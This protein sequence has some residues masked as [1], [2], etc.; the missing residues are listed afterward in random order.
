LKFF[1]KSTKEKRKIV[2]GFKGCFL[3]LQ[4]G[5]RKDDCDA[6]RKARDCRYC[7]GK[8]HT[9]LHVEDE[10]TPNGE[11]AG[12]NHSKLVVSYNCQT[13]DASRAIPVETAILTQ[14][15]MIAIDD[16]NEFLPV[17][18]LFDSGANSNA[19]SSKLA[20]KL[21]LNL[22]KKAPYSVA[23]AGG[24]THN[25]QAASAEIVL[26]N[27]DLSN[28]RKMSVK[29]YGSPVGS[30]EPTNWS[31]CKDQW[32]HLRHLQVAPP[33]EGGV[34]VLIGMQDAD[35]FETSTPS[36][37]GKPGEPVAKFTCLGWTIAGR[38]RRNPVPADVVNLSSAIAMS[39]AEEYKEELISQGSQQFIVEPQAMNTPATMSLTKKDFDRKNENSSCER[40]GKQK[41]RRNGGFQGLPPEVWS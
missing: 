11:S 24:K 37:V 25:Y 21:G 3:C 19:M 17:N 28:K 26:A 29:V 41:S 7:S 5:H 34:D 9:W 6:P 32:E 33:V 18:V 36:I 23:V 27:M 35:A 1:G 22:T 31:E 4:A 16:E 15:G 2:E 39:V 13:V 20:K 40:E 12:K 38:T 8:H 14:T 10:A 30:I